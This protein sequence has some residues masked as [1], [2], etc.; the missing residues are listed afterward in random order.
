MR[1]NVTLR[2]SFSWGDQFGVFT[3]VDVSGSGALLGGT[4]PEAVFPPLHAT[5][6]CGF[7]VDGTDL[8]LEAV[9]VRTAPRGFAV[10][11]VGI[12]L[13]VQDRLVAWVFRKEAQRRSKRFAP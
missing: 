4:S 10:R 12:P 3:T 2:F 1:V 7:S 11:F 6:H 8:R 13:S 9:V 5:G